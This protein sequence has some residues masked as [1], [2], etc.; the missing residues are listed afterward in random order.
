[1]HHASLGDIG[2]R[3][4]KKCFNILLSLERRC[5]SSMSSKSKLF[6]NA[7]IHLH[8]CRQATSWQN[9][10]GPTG[11]RNEPEIAIL[12]NIGMFKYFY[13]YSSKVNSSFHPKFFQIWPMLLTFWIAECTFIHFH[14]VANGCW[15]DLGSS[16]SKALRHRAQTTGLCSEA[17]FSAGLFA[18]RERYF[19]CTN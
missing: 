2:E 8:F 10:S 5:W 15:S 17:F 11:Q 4:K 12:E 14:W 1:M 18:K 3:W 9:L 7:V 19:Q 16:K 6:R 13:V